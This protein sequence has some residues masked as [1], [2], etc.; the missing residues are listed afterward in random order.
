MRDSF[1]WRLNLSR[2][3][4][5]SCQQRAAG[6][7]KRRFVWCA[8]RTLRQGQREGQ[9]AAKRRPGS[10]LD[11]S[12]MFE[13]FL[14]DLSLFFLADLGVLSPGE[15]WPLGACWPGPGQGPGSLMSMRTGDAWQDRR[16]SRERSRSRS[17][18]K[19]RVLWRMGELGDRIGGETERRRRR[20]RGRGM[21]GCLGVKG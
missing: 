20:R 6:W 17:R 5:P 14:V 10:C 13:E 12:R 8:V 16:R 15:G 21:G 19:A 2:Q 11:T 4:D 3:C 18:D 9:G 1:F 7:R